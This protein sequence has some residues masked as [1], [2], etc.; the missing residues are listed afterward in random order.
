MILL[1]FLVGYVNE[2]EVCVGIYELVVVDVY[3]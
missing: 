1:I 3:R 2:D